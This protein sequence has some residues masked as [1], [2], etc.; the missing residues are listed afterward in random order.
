M[1]YSLTIQQQLAARLISKSH[2][3]LGLRFEET[4]KNLLNRP[5]VS[6]SFEDDLR[7]DY[8]GRGSYHL[9]NFLDNLLPEGQLGRLLRKQFEVDEND[10]ASLLALV[11]EDLPGAIRF[12]EDSQSTVVLSEAERANGGESTLPETISNQLRFSLAGVQLKFSMLREGKKL[13][14]PARGKEGD[15]IVKISFG[16]FP[17]LPE[18][19]HA[20]MSWARLVGFS[21]PTTEIWEK[22]DI[23]GL[24]DWVNQDFRALAVRRYD[25]TP[26]GRVHQEDFAQVLGRPP[27]AKYDGKAE[28]MLIIVL[29]ILGHEAFERFIRR[30][31]FTVAIGN[32][33]AHLK[34]WSLFYPD[35]RAPELAP[36]YDQ[37]STIAWPRLDK[38]LSFSLLGSKRYERL[39]LDSW[40]ILAAKFGC[41][42]K[43]CNSI[44]R[45]VEA[46]FKDMRATW[47][48]VKEVLHPEHRKAIEQYWQELPMVRAVGNL[49]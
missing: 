8:W 21:V 15:W 22:E 1:G 43:A 14:L 9:P 39:T 48:E 25:R 28:E 30:L 16:D 35:P 42:D 18:N 3:R 33:D 41:C 19:E 27:G 38:H 11:G 13:A 46:L 6:L 29:R 26:E 12:R 37:V 20:M 40:A 2:S 23:Q 7:R 44:R 47:P 31:A 4:Y 36:L 24:E 5:I 45:Q 32:F 34:N 10:N 49:K 17:S